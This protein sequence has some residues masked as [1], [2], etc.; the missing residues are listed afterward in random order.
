MHRSDA[1]V[2]VLAGLD[3]EH[4]C[5]DAIAFWTLLILMDIEEA[6]LNAVRST[7]KGSERMWS[8]AIWP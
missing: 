1:L 2:K 5:R 7:W 6:V 8:V 4:P 3:A